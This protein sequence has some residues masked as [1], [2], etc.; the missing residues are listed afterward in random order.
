[1]W[2]IAVWFALLETLQF[3]QLFDL[4]QMSLPETLQQLWRSFF[5]WLPSLSHY[6]PPTGRPSPPLSRWWCLD[7]VCLGP[8]SF[9][10]RLKAWMT[11]AGFF[12]LPDIRWQVESSPV[13]WKVFLASEAKIFFVTLQSEQV[14]A[15]KH[16][17]RVASCCLSFLP[18]MWTFTK[19]NKVGC[20]GRGFWWLPFFYLFVCLFIHSVVHILCNTAIH[21]ICVKQ[22][23]LITALLIIAHKGRPLS[24]VSLW[25]LFHALKRTVWCCL[26]TVEITSIPWEAY[27]E[28]K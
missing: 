15:L 1:M 21:F 16:R 27:W 20:I 22:I 28:N 7:A 5:P 12:L 17:C 8:A 14:S 4:P 11:P 3:K 9:R 24:Y 2:Y 13:C 23:K 25:Y 26:Y 6:N 19:G 10:A 18:P